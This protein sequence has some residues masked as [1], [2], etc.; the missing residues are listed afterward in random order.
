MWAMGI[1]H[2]NLTFIAH[3]D[4]LKMVYNVQTNLSPNH[5]N[6]GSHINKCVLSIRNVILQSY[7]IDPCINF[8]QLQPLSFDIN[9]TITSYVYQIGFK[10]FKCP[11]QRASF[12][13]SMAFW[14][15]TSSFSVG[16][17]IY[18][19]VRQGGGRVHE[20]TLNDQQG[21]RN[22]HVVTWIEMILSKI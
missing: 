13:I 16:T 19:V 3:V 2:T 6:I 8:R 22:D 5:Q 12:R 10:I 9:H 1:L 20:L 18:Y 11:T 17:S 15:L 14:S 7:K 4:M 21:S